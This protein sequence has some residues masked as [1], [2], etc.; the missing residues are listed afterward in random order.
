M[1]WTLEKANFWSFSVKKNLFPS[2][3]MWRNTPGEALLQDCFNY[4]NPIAQK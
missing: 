4:T 2:T 3:K 1:C